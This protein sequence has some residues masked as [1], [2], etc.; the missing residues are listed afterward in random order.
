MT[1]EDT[2]ILTKHLGDPVWRLTSGK[3]YKIKTADGR[4]IVPFHPRPEQTELLIELLAA[5]EASKE[6]SRI[7]S[8]QGEEAALA[9]MQLD[10]VQKVKLKARRLGFSTTIGVFVADCLGFRANFTAQLI[11]QIADDAT[12]KM[13][14]IVKVAMDALMEIWP[15]QKDKWNDSQLTVSLAAVEEGVDPAPSTFYAGTRGRGG[16]CNFLWAS[17]LGV[18]QFDDV[19]RADEIVSGAFPSARWGVKF[20]ETTWKGGRG[21]KLWD[22]IEPTLEGRSNDWSV[23]FCPWWKDPRNVSN[24]ELDADTFA[25]F[26]KADVRL[27][28]EFGVVLT[29]GQKRWWAQE[30]RTQGIYMKRENPTFL[31]EC[32]EAPVKGV[33]WAEA[34]AKARN[35]GRIT[36]VP[37]D[38]NLEVDTFWDLGAPDNTAIEFIQHRGGFR[39]LISCQQGGW[40]EL[41]NLV[42]SLKARGYKYHIHFLPHDG[43]QTARTGATFEQAFREEL[44][45]QECGGKVI[46]LERATSIWPGVNH[47]T[48]LFNRLLIDK[49][50]TDFV[51]ACEAYRRRPD[52]RNDDS[53]LDEVVKGPES[54]IADSIR[55]L[56]EADMAGYLPTS[57]DA[58][59]IRPYFDPGSLK[60]A[61]VHSASNLPRV[62][63]LAGS[64]G[65]GRAVRHVTATPDPGG[66]MRMWLEPKAGFRHVVTLIGRSLQVWRSDCI[67]G[68]MMLAA[69]PPWIQQPDH[70]L[71]Y[72]WAAQ[73]SAYYGLAPI[74]LDV[75]SHPGGV[76]QLRA[77][78]API[79]ARTQ[80]EGKRPLGQEEPTQHAG[81]EWKPEVAQHALVLLQGRIRTMN[82]ILHC[83][84]LIAHL[85]EF[86]NSADGRPEARDGIAVDLANGAA[87]AALCHDHAGLYRAP[88]GAEHG[89]HTIDGGRGPSESS[90]MRR[91]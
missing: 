52:P 46:V 12:R 22:I 61:S 68:P 31:D 17:E 88:V 77:L 54:H 76:H 44:A 20:V 40:S 74:A 3:V 38:P 2:A 66:W 29:D 79:L 60:A 85:G 81:W 27:K 70:S 73:M 35:E 13:N 10:S 53:F 6:T 51:R 91:R 55:Y 86:Q 36:N 78:G 69:A 71:F 82:V 47:M 9:Q 63:N 1:P 72:L 19:P 14:D 49:S 32:W 48:S 4:G 43:A 84:S 28:H 58:V 50:C 75:V 62:F 57:G 83:P 67:E 64:D 41:P 16:S 45:R 25:Y 42:R 59:A 65:A 15:L 39:H 33:I 87:L 7:L 30:N 8:E 34:I 56:A 11:D 18:I 5:V 23:S 24:A 26:L 90:R 89:G 37:H 21:G 80:I